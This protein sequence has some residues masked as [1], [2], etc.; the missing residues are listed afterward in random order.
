[1]LVVDVLLLLSVF[2]CYMLLSLSGPADPSLSNVSAFLIVLSF[3][4]ALFLVV[5]SFSTSTIPAAIL[6]HS[7]LA[8]E[9]R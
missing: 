6:S 1:L 4:R 5:N 7:C 2:S 3:V 8:L 9:L